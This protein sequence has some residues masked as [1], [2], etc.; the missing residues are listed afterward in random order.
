MAGEISCFWCLENA[1]F[2]QTERKMNGYHR[3]RL[4]QEYT[5]ELGTLPYGSEIDILGDRI[6]FNG[7]MVEPQYYGI[8]ATLV[9]FLLNNVLEQF[10]Y[11]LT[12]SAYHLSHTWT[13][14]LL[15]LAVALI[16]NSL[17]SEYSLEN[18]L[19]EIL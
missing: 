8:L 19:G 6:M 9:T 2:I 16:G 18:L 1:T 13:L 11:V 4:V 17:I 14:M 3:F 15:S 5:C 7:G 12:Y 10:K